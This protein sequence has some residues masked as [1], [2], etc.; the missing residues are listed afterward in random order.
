M[1]SIQNVYNATVSALFG[2]RRTDPH[3]YSFRRVHNGSTD[4]V[5]GP[6]C[7]NLSSGI[8]PRK[9]LKDHG[10][11]MADV[12]RVERILGL[13]YRE[14]GDRDFLASMNQ[15]LRDKE[16]ELG[17]DQKTWC[18]KE[19]KRIKQIHGLEF[20]KSSNIVAALV[21]W[22][23]IKSP[24]KENSE[25]HQKWAFPNGYRGDRSLAFI[26]GFLHWKLTTDKQCKKDPISC[27]RRYGIILDKI[28]Y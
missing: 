14:S 25:F 16:L 23:N 19:L 6:A 27:I 26:S 18:A 22:C 5:F 2:I 10:F 17:L 12:D 24:I 15:K 7:W 9:W 8:A 13:G 3:P 21:L 1:F 4:V 11:D 28:N 20:V